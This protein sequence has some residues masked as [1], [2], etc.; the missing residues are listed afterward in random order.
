MAEEK[1]KKE[2]AEVKEKVKE[3]KKV[4]ETNNTPNNSNSTINDV[5]NKFTNTIAGMYKKPLSTIKE[6]TKNPNMRDTWIMLVAVA[7]SFALVIT[8][9]FKSIMALSYSGISIDDFVD[10]PYLK[11]FIYGTIIYLVMSFIP[12]IAS[13]IVSRVMKDDKFD[14][15]KSMSLYA[16]SMSVVIPVNLLMALLY[17]INFLPWVGTI[18]VAVVSVFSFFNYILGYLSLN[19]IEDDK[20]AWAL[21]SL[22]IV[23]VVVAFF[24]LALILGSASMSLGDD[25]TNPTHHT[26]YS[27]LINW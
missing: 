7:I 23:W 13:F 17:L 5:W 9:G 22:V 19:E 1:K 10:V 6:E 4:E 27:D 24:G 8:T 21:T 20:K 25:M 12:I 16:T 3:E 18:L 26:N 14:F 15:K 2:T 11:I